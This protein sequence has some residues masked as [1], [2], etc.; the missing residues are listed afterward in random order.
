MI[1]PTVRSLGT[2]SVSLSQIDLRMRP[3]PNHALQRTR[4]GALGSRQVK[5]TL[6]DRN[7]IK[8]LSKILLLGIFLLPGCATPQPRATYA[9][10]EVFSNLLFEELGRYGK[11]DRYGQGLS[12]GKYSI[13]R[14]FS[15]E[16]SPDK[17][18]PDRLYNAAK[19]A[20]D[21]WKGF[22]GY[23]GGG[24]ENEFDMDYG[25]QNTHVFIHVVAYPQRGR[26]RVDVFIGSFDDTSQPSSLRPTSRH[27]GPMTGL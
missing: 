2:Q 4:G 7:C 22:S 19:A 6:M 24:G 21:H 27:A 13:V 15:C 8:V 1:V 3:P 12:E 11:V 18:S 5:F 17:F 16:L 9:S 10:A 20:A 23:S 25:S 14:K 26:T